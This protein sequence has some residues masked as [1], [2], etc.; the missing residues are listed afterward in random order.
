[1]KILI[2]T[3]HS[4]MLWQFRR[5]LIQELLKKGE[6]IISTPF[7]GHEEDFA[8]MGC[9]CIRT[10]FERR[11]INPWREIQLFSFY[12]KLLKAEKPD[13]VLTYS[14]KPNIYAGILSRLCKI[15]YCVNVQGLGSAFQRF[16]ISRGITVLYRLALHGASTVFFE[17]KSNEE[18]FLE[19]RIT[20]KQNVVVL[21]GAGVN[22]SE[23]YQQPYPAENEQIHFLYM[24]RIMREKGFDELVKAAKRIKAE[25]GE[26]V[27][28]DLV[29]F[30][31]EN[32]EGIIAD[33]AVNR[34]VVFHGFQYDSRPYYASAH[35][36]VLP[37]YHEG[38]SNV[39]LE[40]ASIGRALIT[41]DIPGCREAVE[42][43]RTGFLV[44]PQDPESLYSAIKAF[45]ALEPEQREQMGILGRK[46]MEREFDK[47]RVVSQ[48]L[49]A[50]PL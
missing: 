16:G 28:F 26:R 9:R 38:M 19:K 6:V 32:Y 14:V 33:L 20:K 35:C 41:T 31:E 12:R 17:N 5:E 50:L 15:P 4:Y 47:A 7:M 30:F 40:A 24:G 25:Y 44:K 1:M 21:P 10:D 43:G 27:V 18:F 36:V 2:V 45:L 11:N 37:S 22:L 29:G 42:E 34:T 49:A 13:L 39:L 48:T 46:K 8:A 3:N 23:Y